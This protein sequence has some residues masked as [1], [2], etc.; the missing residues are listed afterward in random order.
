LL[1][2]YGRLWLICISFLLSK[3]HILWRTLLVILSQ[4]RGCAS[5]INGAFW[6][7]VGFIDI[8]FTQ[9]GTIYNT[10]PSLI[11][12]LYSSLLHMH[13]CSHSLLAISWQQISSLCHFISHVKSSFHRLIPFL[14]FLL[15]HLRLLTLS[16]PSPA[17]PKHILW[18][19]GISKLDS[20]LLNW[21]LLYNH[22]ARTTQKTQPLSCW[23]GLFTV[24]LHSNGSYLIVACVFIA[25]GM[26][27]ISFFRR[28]N[29]D[30]IIR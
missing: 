23:E 9:L 30:T 14:P 11:Y 20:V 21:T 19:A 22:F 16:I 3:L 12:T 15:S 1:I 26:C 18:L 28:S 13:Y 25:M 4:F 10:A 5:L 2:W 24:P 17:V 6:L 29:A 27:F 8:L 7:N